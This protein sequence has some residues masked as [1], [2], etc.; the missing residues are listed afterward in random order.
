MF[1]AGFGGGT[2]TAF[3]GGGFNAFQPAQQ[4]TQQTPGQGF[5]L[6]NNGTIGQQPAGGGGTGNPA[7][8]PVP[9]SFESLNRR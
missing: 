8:K 1:G 9:V 4:Q 7:F 2:T 3:G 5:T 6:S